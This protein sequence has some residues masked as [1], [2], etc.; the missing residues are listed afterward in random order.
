MSA[1]CTHVENMDVWHLSQAMQTLVAVRHVVDLQACISSHQDQDAPLHAWVQKV[2]RLID[3][4][5]TALT[6]ELAGRQHLG[7]DDQSIRVIALHRVDGLVLGAPDL[8]V[9]S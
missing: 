7:R 8:G 6:L 1:P 4:E 2:E 5:L 3:A 9:A